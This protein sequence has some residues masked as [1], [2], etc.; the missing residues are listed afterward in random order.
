M[1][2]TMG[3]TV[4]VW[5]DFGGRLDPGFAYVMFIFT[6]VYAKKIRHTL[7]C[8]GFE[9]FWVRLCF[10]P[11]ETFHH[12][13]IALVGGPMFLSNN[14]HTPIFTTHGKSSLLQTS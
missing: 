2:V 4:E 7:A 10:C 14:M 5:G 13:N 9:N 1:M 11:A 12:V 3:G 8:P 6:N